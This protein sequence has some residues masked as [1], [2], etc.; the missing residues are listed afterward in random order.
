MFL[1]CAFHL[2]SLTCICLAMP[3]DKEDL[4]FFMRQDLKEVC[5][6]FGYDCTV[7][8]GFKIETKDGYIYSFRCTDGKIMKAW[9]DLKYTTWNIPMDSSQQVPPAGKQGGIV[10]KPDS[11]TNAEPRLSDEAEK[12]KNLYIQILDRYPKLGTL[13]RKP[14]LFLDIGSGYIIKSDPLVEIMIPINDWNSLSET[15]RDLLAKYASGLVNEVKANPFAYSNI[16]AS[17]P[18]APRIR[19]SVSNMT[20]YSWIIHEGEIFE[21]EGEQQMNPG[22]TLLSGKK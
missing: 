8:D 5:K 1:V 21:D 22:K 20:S 6:K 19:Q 3:G 12:G 14:F 18:I 7:S 2:L 16:P 10:R 9:S 11:N 15:D 4:G 17:A 13:S